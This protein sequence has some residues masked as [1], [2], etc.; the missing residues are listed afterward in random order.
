M[1]ET[2]DAKRKELPSYKEMDCFYDNLSKSENKLAVLSLINPYF[3]KLCSFI[4]LT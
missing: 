3:D 4:H 1:Q 2:A